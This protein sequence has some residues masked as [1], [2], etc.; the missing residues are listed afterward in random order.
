MKAILRTWI[1]LSNFVFSKNT[2]ALLHFLNLT[3][4]S[5]S[6]L[7]PNPFVPAFHT[8]SPFS[9]P[10]LFFYFTALSIPASAPL[11]NHVMAPF[12]AQNL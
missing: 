6:N 2:S 9:K 10:F 7:Q 8:K 12:V 11:K 4:T 5:T 1:P 3:P